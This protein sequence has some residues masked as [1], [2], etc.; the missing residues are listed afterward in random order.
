MQQN[1]DRSLPSLAGEVKIAHASILSP[2]PWAE[3]PAWRLRV[4]QLFG[5][6]GNGDV[7][8][9]TP[10]SAMTFRTSEASAG[11]LRDLLDGIG[12]VVS[13]RRMFDVA[14][15]WDGS[16][17]LGAAVFVVT[18]QHFRRAGP[19]RTHRSP[20]SPTASRAPWRRPHIIHS[21]GSYWRDG[22]PP[23]TCSP[24]DRQTALTAD[25][26]IAGSRA[27]T[28]D[29]GEPSDSTSRATAEFRVRA[30]SN[31]SSD[32][33]NARSADRIISTNPREETA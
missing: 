18:P 3:T 19:V 25:V 13:G 6:Y 5:W 30:S 33:N 12:A 1:D 11:H 26:P 16:H 24:L 29:S 21:T 15:G 10:G 28:D 9:P 4:E 22:N 7:T 2:A 27:C 20:S 31:L 14:Q 23:T 32:A 8:V 17:P